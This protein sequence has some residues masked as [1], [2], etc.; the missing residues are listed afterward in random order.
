MK[1]PGGNEVTADF[2]RLTQA[3]G[4]LEQE[5]QWAREKWSPTLRVPSGLNPNAVFQ[6][7]LRVLRFPQ[8]YQVAQGER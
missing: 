3:Q 1:R 6:S 5:P 2:S 4:G 7:P 8:Y